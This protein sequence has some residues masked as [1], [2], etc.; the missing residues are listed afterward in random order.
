MAIQKINRDDI[1]FN[2]VYGTKYDAENQQ[3]SIKV[4][5]VYWGDN[6]DL[7]VDDETG[8][9][10]ENGVALGYLGKDSITNNQERTPS[11]ASMYNGSYRDESDIMKQEARIENIDP[12]SSGVPQEYQMVDDNVSFDE[13]SDNQDDIETIVT[14]DELIGDNE[15]DSEIKIEDTEEA[16]EV[17]P[18][19]NT[20]EET[21]V[22]ETPAEE[23]NTP[24]VPGEEAPSE[25]EITPIEESVSDIENEEI[26][27][28]LE[29]EENNI[30]DNNINDIETTDLNFANIIENI[31]NRV[32]GFGGNNG[33]SI[34]EDA[35]RSGNEEVY[36]ENMN[37]LLNNLDGVSSQ[38]EADGK[39]YSFQSTVFSGGNHATGQNNPTHIMGSKADLRFYKDGV[40][41]DVYNTTQEDWQYIKDVLGD[42]NLGVQF[43]KHNTVWG[44]V[45]LNDAI[46]RYG[47]HVTYDNGWGSGTDIKRV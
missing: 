22:E 35:K 44:D 17:T 45:F 31:N 29:T 4:N 5:E 40:Q 32:D 41:L 7:F 8:L 37:N 43:E 13:D 38:F 26:P 46:N 30:S 23:N 36:M 15:V 12:L 20:E 14:T 27:Q 34:F 9:V 42:N 24:V 1:D 2:K 18:V 10:T 16:P 3:N 11:P 6:G 19:E 33:H 39:G 21:L 47:E 25:V 28:D